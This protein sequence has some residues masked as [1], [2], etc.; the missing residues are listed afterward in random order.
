MLPLD[1]QAMSAGSRDDVP[2]PPRRSG[3]I[4]PPSWNVAGIAKEQFQR[5]RPGSRVFRYAA[6]GFLLGAALT[7]GGYVV[8]YHDLYGHLPPSLGIGVVRGLHAVSPVHYFADLFALV[9]ALAG[10]VAGWLQDRVVFYSSRLED[11]VEERT[12]DLSHLA[13]H[14]ALTGL[15]NRTVLLDRMER[16]LAAGRRRDVK[17][18]V[19]HVGLDRFKKVNQ[20]LGQLVGDRVLVEAARRLSQVVADFT[21]GAPGLDMTGSVFRFEGDEF[22]VVLEDVRSLR[23][24]TRL[25]NKILKTHEGPIGLEVH[26]VKVSLS[27]GIAFGS[28]RS[29]GAA[30]LLRDAQTSMHRAKVQGRARVEVFD[31][32]MLKSVQDAM[33]LETELFQTLEARRLHVWYQPIFDLESRRLAGFEALVRW[34][35]PERGTI[36]PG[37]FI[38]LAEETGLIVRMSQQ[39]FERAIMQLSAWMERFGGRPGVALSLNLSPKWLLHPEMESDLG[40]LLSE[41]G[42]DPARIHL[43]IT[44]TSFIDE[45]RAVAE[46]VGRLK[47]W[48]FGIALD[49]FGTGYSSLSML[50]ELPI[51]TLKIDQRFVAELS[52]ERAV[53]KIVRTIVDLGRALGLSVTAEGIETERQLRSLRSMGCTYGQGFLLGRPMHAEDAESLLEASSRRPVRA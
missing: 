13:L 3:V 19:L 26:E 10:G 8:D 6:C 16:I 15:A 53:A 34:D 51:D 38:P 20:G 36:P 32:K 12:R 30:E 33:H 24:A 5:L 7:V 40:A 49:D 14:D 23:D 31:R 2:D 21:A 35:H 42:A 45:P 37:Q 41:S 27:I 29:S 39:L 11:L 1:V 48:G 44:E 43:E 9:L 52:E 50:H 46:I 18:A 25:A 4:R 22:V 28:A 47:D 17:V